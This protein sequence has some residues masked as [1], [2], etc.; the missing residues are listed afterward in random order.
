MVFIIFAISEEV[1]F[2]SSIAVSISRIFSLPSLTRCLEC[3]AI[4]LALEAFCALV[5]MVSDIS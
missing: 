3:P 2:I 5:V 4:S 1:V